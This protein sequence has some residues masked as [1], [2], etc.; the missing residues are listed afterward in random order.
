MIS[1]TIG[2]LPVG[3]NLFKVSKI[4]IEKRPFGLCPDV[5]FLTLKRFLITGKNNVF[6]P[7]K[8]CSKSEN[9]ARKEQRPLGLCS[10]VI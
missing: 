2:I 6:Q 1:E 8:P 10:S 4:T 9:N 5:I 3:K 7:P